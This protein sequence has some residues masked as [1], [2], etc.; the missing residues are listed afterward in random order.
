MTHE[1]DGHEVGER[2]RALKREVAVVKADVSEGEDIA[3]MLRFVRETFGRLDIIVSNAASGG[4]RSLLATTDHDFQAAMNTNVR[5]LL[6]LMQ[7][8][9]EL[10]E[11]QRR[12]AMD[13]LRDPNLLPRI[14]EDFDTAGVVGERTG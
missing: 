11:E 9:V 2:I 7:S 3:D 1:H 6:Y 10:S 5:P 4:F 8:A 14:V 12:E 13:L